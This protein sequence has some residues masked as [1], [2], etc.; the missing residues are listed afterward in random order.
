MALSGGV[1]MERECSGTY[2]DVG[3][4]PAKQRASVTVDIDGKLYQAIIS[5]LLHRVCVLMR[6]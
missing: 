2:D 4:L 6:V 5:G 3:C 1:G